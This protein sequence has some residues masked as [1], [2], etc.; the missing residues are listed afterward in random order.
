MKSMNFAINAKNNENFE[1]EMMIQ[2][3]PIYNIEFYV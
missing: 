1:T 3:L 2:I